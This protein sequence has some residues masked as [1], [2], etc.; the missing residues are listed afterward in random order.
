MDKKSPDVVDLPRLRRGEGLC[1]IGSRQLTDAMRTSM[2]RGGLF[3]LYQLLVVV[4][5]VMMPVALLARRAGIN[6]PLARA[7]ESVGNAYEAAAAR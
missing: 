2:Y 1:R 5:I 4:G 6:L 7:L 3:V